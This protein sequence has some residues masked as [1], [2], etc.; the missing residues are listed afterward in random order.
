MTFT[1]RTFL[2]G[3]S[4]GLIALPHIATA[5]DYLLEVDTDFRMRFIFNGPDGAAATLPLRHEDV[6]KTVE[7]GPKDGLAFLSDLVVTQAKA[8][9][10]GFPEDTEVVLQM[11]LREGLAGVAHGRVAIRDLPFTLGDGSWSGILSVHRPE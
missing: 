10:A 11:V 1:K 9:M 7:M 8:E 4:S 3:L 2:A 6:E 5:S